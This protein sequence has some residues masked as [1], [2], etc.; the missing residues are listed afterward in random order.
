MKETALVT[1]ASSGI[2]RELS[3]VFAKKGI[4]LVISARS[5]EK[6]KALKDE[7]EKRY[8]IQVVTVEKDLSKQGAGEELYSGIKDKG[9]EIDYLVN[10]AGTGG[11]GKYHE[12]SWDADRDM[13]NLNITALSALT[14]FFLPDMLERNSGKILNIGSGAGFVPGPLQAVYYASKAY[15]ASLSQAIAEEVRDSSVTV[16]LYCPSATDTGFADAGGLN[17]V[18]QFQKKLDTPEE[19]AEKAF[20]AMMKGKLAVLHDK[21]EAFMIRALVPLLPR[22]IVLKSSRKRMEK[23]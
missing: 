15:V 19:V 14:K 2:G 10:N 16:T 11:H 7:L 5:G 9:I 13:I 6:L 8:G 21:G 4:N 17:K 22:K 20:E 1:G 12:R 18:K 3:K 23:A